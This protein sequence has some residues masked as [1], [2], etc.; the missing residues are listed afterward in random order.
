[1]RGRTN[2]ARW[3]HYNSPHGLSS[4]MAVNKDF[5]PAVGQLGRMQDL[6]G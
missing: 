5:T 2:W 1:M 4:S 6:A 3:K